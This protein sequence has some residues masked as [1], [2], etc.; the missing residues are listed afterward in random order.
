[1][2]EATEHSETIESHE[3]A[4]RPRVR[5][6]PVLLRTLDLYLQAALAWLFQVLLYN[7]I[8]LQD[9]ILAIAVIRR[10]VVYA[11]TPRCQQTIAKS[12]RKPEDHRYSLLLAW[13][14]K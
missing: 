9:A 11:L 5:G 13:F 6:K 12:L 1:M 3:L 8:D 10:L 4:V 2:P 14:S 7:F